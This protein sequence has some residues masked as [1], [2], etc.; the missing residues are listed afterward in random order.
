MVHG[1]TIE[2]YRNSFPEAEMSAV[3]L[4]FGTYPSDE[5][6]ALLVQ[7][8]LLVQQANEVPDELMAEIKAQLLEYH[9]PQN[10]EWRCAFWTRSLQVIRQAFNALDTK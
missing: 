6:L 4:E 1:H 3:T 10:W 7:E 9:H 2:A 5:T 8:H